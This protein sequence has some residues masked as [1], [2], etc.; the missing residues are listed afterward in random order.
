MSDLEEK[1]YRVKYFP[2]NDLACGL[3]LEKVEHLFQ[4]KDQLEIVDINDAIEFYNIYLYFQDK[5]LKWKKW[6]DEQID[7]FRQF[8]ITLKQKT[9][10]FFNTISE[11]NIHNEHKKL[12]F[13]Y[14][15]DFVSLFE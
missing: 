14:H 8:S 7:L 5:S 11:F 9:F 15:D 6:N 3:H 10:S 13:E 4:N 2:P 12:N 1:E